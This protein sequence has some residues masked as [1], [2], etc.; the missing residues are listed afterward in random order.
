[1]RRSAVLL[2]HHPYLFKGTVGDNVSFGLKLRKLPEAEVGGRVREALALVELDGWQAKPASGLSAGQAQ[3]VALARVLALRP[4]A[5]LLDEPTANI[6]AALGLR[7]ESVLREA[8]R[9]WGTTVVFSTHNFSQASRLADSILYLSEGRRVEFGHENCFSGTAA[10]DG[11]MSWIEPK[12]GLRI[13][14]PGAASG[15][16][17]C[18]IDPAAIRVELGREGAEKPSGPNVFRGRV[19]RMETTDGA[20]A[21]VRTSGDLV[22]RA[23]VPVRD[24]EA[25]GIS[26]STEVLLT[27]EPASVRLI[28]EGT[29]DLAIST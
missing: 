13:V 2:T 25:A 18:V 8:G 26:L 19:S 24:L 9:A 27:F 5:L 7:M 16:V 21:L 3:R 15:H 4:K 14:F 22:F 29:T 28:G 6:D 20:T 11:R 23:S 10:T 1:A 17:T 12:A